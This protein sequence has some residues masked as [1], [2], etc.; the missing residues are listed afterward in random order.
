[1]V[2]VAEELV[3]DP[4]TEGSPPQWVM[5]ESAAIGILRRHYG[6]S[7]VVPGHLVKMRGPTGDVGG[8]LHHPT[9]EASAS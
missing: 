2:P 4:V 6:W 8:S 9:L 1:M 7:N 3:D 5:A